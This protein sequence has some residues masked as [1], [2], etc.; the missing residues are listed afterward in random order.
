MAEYDPSKAWVAK[1]RK[2]GRVEADLLIYMDEFPPTGPDV[3]EYWKASQRAAIVCNHL[4]IQ[5]APRKKRGV[6]RSP[7]PWAGSMV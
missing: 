7:G 1:A 6:S 5:Y 2:D 4:V 3:E